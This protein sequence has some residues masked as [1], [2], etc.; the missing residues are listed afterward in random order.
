M[1]TSISAPAPG[2]N[3]SLR[4]LFRNPRIA[5]TLIL[6][7]MAI[8]TYILFTLDRSNILFPLWSS[9]AFPPF[10]LTPFIIFASPLSRRSKAALILLM[11]L[12]IMPLV[13]IFDGGYL[14][15]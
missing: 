2:G 7:Y 11:I 14:E 15:L 8:F 4:D 10:V 12:I 5:G 6:A 13:G 9:L 3:G 1:N